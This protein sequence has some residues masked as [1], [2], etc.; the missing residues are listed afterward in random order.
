MRLI[1]SA[2]LR[3]IGL[4]I[5]EA[6]ASFRFTL[7]APFERRGAATD[8][9]NPTAPASAALRLIPLERLIRF[10]PTFS[11][12]QHRSSAPA[13]AARRLDRCCRG[14]HAHRPTEPPDGPPRISLLSIAC[15]GHINREQF[16]IGQY[17][18]LMLIML[19]VSPIMRPCV[20]WKAISGGGEDATRF[21]LSWC[22]SDHE[23]A[24]SFV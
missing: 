22:W 5:C 9:P 4:V 8:K 12:F 20:L 1:A 21:C 7:P 19:W 23:A 16:N 17:N 15:V 14:N 3:P 6:M 13:G 11:D 2:D 24:A 18:F 10:P